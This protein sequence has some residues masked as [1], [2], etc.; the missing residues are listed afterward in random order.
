MMILGKKIIMMFFWKEDND[1]F[2]EEKYDN[3]W[4]RKG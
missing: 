1:D 2:R 3:L 4:I